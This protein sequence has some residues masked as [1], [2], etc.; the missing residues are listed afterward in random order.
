MDVFFLIS[1]Y[2]LLG[3]SKLTK[4]NIF[5]GQP[6]IIKVYAL[7]TIL[8]VINSGCPMTFHAIIFIGVIHA[9][10]QT[11]LSLIGSEKIKNYHVQNPIILL[12]ELTK[13]YVIV[14]LSCNMPL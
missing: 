14:C 2:I 12:S 11:L 13:K 10:R 4:H 8:F 5:T 7:I 6:L 9:K 3:I 1:A